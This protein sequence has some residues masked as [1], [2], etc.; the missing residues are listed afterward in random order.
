VNYD[1]NP[2]G[3][4]EITDVLDQ[5][6]Y[7]Y[8][9]VGTIANQW[10]AIPPGMTDDLTALLTMTGF[11]S[12]FNNVAN[13]N[14]PPI[15]F[16][17]N[18]TQLIDNAIV[19]TTGFLEAIYTCSNISVEFVTA[20][21]DVAMVMYYIEIAIWLAIVLLI[22]G[23]YVVAIIRQFPTAFV[24]TVSDKISSAAQSVESK[25][26]SVGDSILSPS[27]KAN[28]VWL[29]NYMNF[30]ATILT[31]SYGLL[32]FILIYALIPLTGQCLIQVDVWVNEAV[33]PGMDKI[34]GEL[35][36]AINQAMS[37]LQAD[38]NAQLAFDTANATSS[39]KGTL[40]DILAVKAQYLSQVNDILDDIKEQEPI[41]PGVYA[42]LTC[43]LPLTALELIDESINQVIKLM[44]AL[45]G[46]Q[47]VV[48]PFPLPNFSAVATRSLRLATVYV[49]NSIQNDL[50][51]FEA[52]FIVLLAAIGV[53]F[54]QGLFFLSMKKGLKRI[55]QRRM[56]SL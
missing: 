50:Q 45:L 55:R 46:I 3:A 42:A 18:A 21:Q 51:K 40:N 34:T 24:N 29:L 2:C 47:V 44:N 12:D 28:I 8:G 36:T 43:V 37:G 22:V 27:T 56:V 25:A 48:P 13:F 5:I 26:D 4:S 38:L 16:S 53:L 17:V 7:I 33:A 35:Q 1:F 19:N 20:T 30:K 41:G 9:Q 15:I 31:S 52:I 23:I 6:N 39:L 49:V 11:I 14:A 32:G 10:P 54:L